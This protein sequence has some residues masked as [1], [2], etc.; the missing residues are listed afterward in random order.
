[1]FNPNHGEN[2]LNSLSLLLENYLKM[3][4]YSYIIEVYVLLKHNNCKRQIN[5]SAEKILYIK[6]TGSHN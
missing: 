6:N 1:M 2:S 3:Y 5:Y 4:V